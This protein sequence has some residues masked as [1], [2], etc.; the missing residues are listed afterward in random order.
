VFGSR[1]I[2]R[3][4]RR[5]EPSATPVVGNTLY[6]QQKRV[7]SETGEGGAGLRAEALLLAGRTMVSGI[8]KPGG[9]PGHRG[10][11]SVDLIRDELGHTV[12]QDRGTRGLAGSSWIILR[13]G[14]SCAV[15]FGRKTRGRAPTAEVRREFRPWRGGDYLGAAIV[16]KLR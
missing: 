16:G 2:T 14:F 1:R 4:P 7:E 5:S 10:P 15:N 11:L 3:I 12:L 13:D 6:G 8:E 9:R